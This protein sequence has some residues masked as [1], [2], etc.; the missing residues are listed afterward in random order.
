MKAAFIEHLP[1]YQSTR[2]VGLSQHS[3][4]VS[5]NPLVNSTVDQDFLN[6]FYH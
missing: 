5:H 2:V 6:R 4:T 3:W 1:T